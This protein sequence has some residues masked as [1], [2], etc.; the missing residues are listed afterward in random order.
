MFSS[1]PVELVRKIFESTSTVVATLDS[2]AFQIRASTLRQLSLVCSG[3]CSV[4][5]ALLFEFVWVKNEA[6]LEHVLQVIEL[7]EESLQVKVLILG[8]STRD[9]IQL[10]SFSLDRIAQLCPNLRSL[11]ISQSSDP[12]GVFAALS[13][14]ARQLF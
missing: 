7:K 8:S 12:T 6:S 1:L 11:T 4:A 13:R 3:F 2:K 14:F 10:S 9:H 5:Q